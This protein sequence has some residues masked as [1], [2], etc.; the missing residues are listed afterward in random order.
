MSRNWNYQDDNV[1]VSGNYLDLTSKGYNQTNAERFN[2]NPYTGRTVFLINN[3]D[4][5]HSHVSVDDKGNY[6][7]WGKNHTHNKW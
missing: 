6:S 7:N 2:K 3:G 4:G 1:K 5:T